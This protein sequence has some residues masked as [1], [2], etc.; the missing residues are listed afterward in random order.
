[1]QIRAPLQAKWFWYSILCVIFWGA[2]AILEKMGSQEISPEAVQFLF[3]FG[4]LPV[5]LGLL[6]A[7]R[8]KLQR[9]PIGVFYALAVGVFAGVGNA[10]LAA[11]Y[12]ANGSTS[13]ITAVT[14]M[15]PMMTVIL[16]RFVL[17]ER[18]TRVHIIGLGFAAVALVTFSL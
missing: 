8:F 1:V 13:V 12:R 17:R 6:L 10:A 18:L 15:Y 11:A 9:K 2:W 4:G 7:Q 3:A 16:A 14:A 5:A